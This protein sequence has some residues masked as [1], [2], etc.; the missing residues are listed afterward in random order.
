MRYTVV[1]HRDALDRLATIWMD[2][3]DRNAVAHA[4]DEIDRQLATDPLNVGESREHILRIF[5][6]WPLGVRYFV[7]T[8]DRL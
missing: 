4:S 8:K 2:A 3:D 5:F 6:E 1:W 7:S